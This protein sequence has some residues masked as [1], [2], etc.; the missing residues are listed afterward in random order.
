MKITKLVFTEEV[1]ATTPGTATS[2]S[3]AACVRLFNNQAGIVTV[4][5][6]TLVGAATTMSFSLPTLAIEFVKKNPTDVIYTTSAIKATNVA[7]Y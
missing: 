2:I 3:S 7:Q 6:S 1:T 5:I 4:G